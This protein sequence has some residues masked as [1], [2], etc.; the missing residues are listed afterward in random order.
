MTAPRTTAASPRFL[1]PQDKQANRRLFCFPYKDAPPLD[2]LI[3]APGGLHD[4]YI[5]RE[6]ESPVA[7]GRAG[8]AGVLN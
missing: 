7:R 8:V 1:V 5:T 6:K 4:R 2:C 3:T